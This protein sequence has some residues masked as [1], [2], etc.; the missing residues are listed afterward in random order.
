MK[1]DK[2][3]DRKGTKDGGSD[4]L[5]NS[6]WQELS[7]IGVSDLFLAEIIQKHDNPDFYTSKAIRTIIDKQFEKKTRNI[8]R[9][10]FF[11]YFIGFLVPYMINI[12]I[13]ASYN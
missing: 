6:Y 11:A 13:R 9:I 3:T 12:M 2:F 1:I 4:Y 10:A 8:E 5:D 7:Q